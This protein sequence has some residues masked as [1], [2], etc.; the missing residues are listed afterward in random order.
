[1]MGNIAVSFTPVRDGRMHARIIGAR[2]VL[3]TS[4]SRILRVALQ[5]KD[6]QEA[7]VEAG[8]AQLKRG[9]E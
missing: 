4:P 1:M 5:A 3:T 9:V 8:K 2:M 6:V 7:E